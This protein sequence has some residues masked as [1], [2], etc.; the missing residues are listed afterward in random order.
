LIADELVNNA[1]EHG[2]SHGDI[3]SCIIRAKK[4]EDNV[5]AIELEIHDTGKGKDAK[6]ATHMEKIKSEKTKTQKNGIYMEKRGRGLFH[7]TEKLVDELS[8]S[9]SPK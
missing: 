4:N 1:I 9:E 7:I 6:D 5:F 3:D 8:F 2:S